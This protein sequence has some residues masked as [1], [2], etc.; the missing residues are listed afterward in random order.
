MTGVGRMRLGIVALALAAGLLVFRIASPDAVQTPT[1]ERYLGTLN[2]YGNSGDGTG[3][4]RFREHRAIFLYLLDH[5]H[6]GVFGLG[7]NGYRRLMW[8]GSATMMFGH[9]IYLHTLYELGLPG[10]VLLGWWLW[11]LSDLGTHGNASANGNRR[12]CGMLLLALIVQRLVAGW[13]AD[14]LFAPEGMLQSNVLF[15][16]LAGMVYATYRVP[17]DVKATRP[18]CASS[19]VT[20]G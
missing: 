17:A 3:G 1:M 12:E 10:F 8:H 2:E 4:H 11:R 13:G 7:S 20:S 5:P 9:N 15:L 19:A 6:I 18:W 16:G 14:T